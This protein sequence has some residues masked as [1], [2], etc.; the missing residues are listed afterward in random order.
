LLDI[1]TFNLLVSPNKIKKPDP[2]H[3]HL[4]PT[5]PEMADAEEKI[6]II[7]NGISISHCTRRITK[8]TS[9]GKTGPGQVGLLV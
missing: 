1:K 5:G 6:S 2:R 3:V 4:F 7:R 8:I 9:G